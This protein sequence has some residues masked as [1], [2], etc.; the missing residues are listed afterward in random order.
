MHFL[1]EELAVAVSVVT[2]VHHT[3]LSI[4]LLSNYSI[5]PLKKEISTIF[6]GI[7]RVYD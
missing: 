5:Q 2:E 6:F 1:I 7:Q 4:Y 3:P